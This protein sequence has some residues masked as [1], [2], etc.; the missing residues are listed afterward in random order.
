MTNP[1]NPLWYFAWD[2]DNDEE[3]PKDDPV[4]NVSKRMSQKAHDDY[5]RRT[6]QAAEER[7]AAH[8]ARKAE[9]QTRSSSCKKSK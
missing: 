3:V 6:R 1:N 7:K 2:D 5:V 8:I 9:E 4:T